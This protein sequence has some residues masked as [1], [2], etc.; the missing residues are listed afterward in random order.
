MV[1]MDKR[2]RIVSY[3]GSP[4]DTV[5][6]ID[7]HVCLWGTGTGTIEVRDAE[8]LDLGVPLLNR[9]VSPL[10]EIPRP[11]APSGTV[12]YNSKSSPIT[13]HYVT[14]SVSYE[15]KPG[16]SRT[17]EVN[18]NSRITYNRGGTLGNITYQ[19]TAGT[20]RFSIQDRAWQVT[21][22]T[23]SVIIDN[24]ANGCDFHCDVDGQPRVIPARKTL[25]LD[26]NY[27]I[28]IRFDREEGQVT[29]CKLIGETPRVT[30]GVAPGSS[31]LDLFPG[32]SQ[33]LC[34]RPVASESIASLTQPGSATPE[35]VGRQ[36]VLP[37]VEDLR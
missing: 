13:V 26:S 25:Q 17:H 2:F 1:T 10:A 14:D 28:S 15:L 18:A 8:L 5:Q 36:P 12:I 22:P 3:P 29:S 6:A 11:P 31:A 19:L 37:T 27:P 20:Y 9:E 4:K 7:P 34:I 33:E 32:S 23:F 16:E 30:V 24:L 21:K 35:K